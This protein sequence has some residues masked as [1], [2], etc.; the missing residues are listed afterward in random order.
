MNLMKCLDKLLNAAIKLAS[1]TRKLN[2]F[3]DC[4]NA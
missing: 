4:H 1:T 3:I 2:I